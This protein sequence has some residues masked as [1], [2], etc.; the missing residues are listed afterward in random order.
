[1]PNIVTRIPP[2]PTGHLHIGTARTA[3]FNYLFA[4][5]YGGKLVFRSEDTD[6]TRSTKKFEAEIIEGL[7][8]LG[9][10]WDNDTIIRQSERAPLY[11]TYLEKMI[12]D[13]TAYLSE[14]ESKNN[15]GETVT[16]V[17]LKNPNKVITFSDLIRGDITFD[18]TELGDVVIARSIDDALYHLTVV[19]DD[20]EMGVTHVLRG[21][22]HISNTPRQILIQEAIGV[23]RPIYAHLPLILATDRS[24]MSKRHGAVSLNEYREAGY[25]KEAIINY[26][27]LLGWN[28]GTDQEL[29]TLNELVE[30]F[31]ERH[32]HKAGAVFDIKKFSW[33]NKEYLD[34]LSLKD[35]TAYIS[36]NFPPQ[37]S[38]LPQYNEDRLTRAI[39]TIRERISTRQEFHELAVAGEYDYFF[40]NPTYETP[41]L[42]WKNDDSLTA[43][44]PRLEKALEMLKTADFTAKE[45]LKSLLWPLAEELG[46]GELLWPLRVALSGQE[47]SPD[48][49][50]LAFI[51]GSEE[52]LLR[53]KIACDKIKV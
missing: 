6:K 40:S 8:W 14:E 3:L 15:P 21:D 9:L 10:S 17:R 53:I 41:I 52:T 12:A 13:G 22:D 23:P 51:L 24:K 46:K 48:P 16:I 4:K 2:S 30:A 7:N 45:G 44:L 38:A 50:T 20:F 1:M 47:R 43:V 34:R 31:D 39:P 35:F 42:K 49:F 26:L 28:P 33:F 36:E 37:L 27:A 25:T 29:F 5:R 18:T 32:I 11:R 19:V